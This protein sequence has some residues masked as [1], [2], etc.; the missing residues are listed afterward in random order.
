MRK[1][2]VTLCAVIV[3]FAVSTNSQDIRVGADLEVCNAQVNLWVAQT[4]ISRPYG[5]E[6]R[7]VMDALTSAAILNREGVIMD[8]VL[9][10]LKELKAVP[11][12]PQRAAKSQKLGIRLDEARTLLD[13]YGKEQRT[14]YFHFITRNELRQ[15]FDQEDKA[16]ER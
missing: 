13:L 6:L 2:I 16:G 9:T 7:K 15:K 10:D 8:C 12:G 5:P 3:C 14:R 11:E 4:D 1:R